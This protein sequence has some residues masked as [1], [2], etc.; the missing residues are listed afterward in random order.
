MLYK[1]LVSANC[2]ITVIYLQVGARM[3]CGSGVL[4]TGCHRL[5]QTEFGEG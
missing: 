2:P 4:A 5:K 3:L 1:S